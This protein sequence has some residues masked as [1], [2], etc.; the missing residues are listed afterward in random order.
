MSVRI[1]SVWWMIGSFANAC[2]LTTL[3]SKTTEA[4]IF[5]ATLPLSDGKD[6]L[7]P[8]LTLALSHL[9]GSL[10]CRPPTRSPSADGDPPNS[11]SQAEPPEV[12]RLRAGHT[13]H[14]LSFRGSE[15][16]TGAFAPRH[17]G[18]QV[19]GSGRATA[20]DRRSHP[21]LSWKTRQALPRRAPATPSSLP[22]RCSAGGRGPGRNPASSN[23]RWPDS[24]R[25]P[26][27]RRCL[28]GCHVA[29]RRFPIAPCRP[30]G[31]S[32]TSRAD[33]LPLLIEAV[34]ARS[35]GKVEPSGVSSPGG[36]ATGDPGG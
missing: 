31:G 9:T 23:S 16:P 20:S 24:R 28:H 29:S 27:C 30:G 34:S 2:G 17:Q 32:K 11:A 6:L 26:W 21:R 7:W 1:T 15:L 33:L 19:L 4:C 3:G 36:E 10:F 18:R 13:E 14:I 5:Q 25:T 12:G 22:S 35:T 8:G